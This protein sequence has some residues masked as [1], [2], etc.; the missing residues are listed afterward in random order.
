[1]RLATVRLLR[2][3]V[4]VLRGAAGPFDAAAFWSAVRKALARGTEGGDAP[5]PAAYARGGARTGR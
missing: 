3:D 2:Y 4:P 5:A 1:M